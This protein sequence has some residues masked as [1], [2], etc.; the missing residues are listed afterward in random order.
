M[1]DDD[2][3]RLQGCCVFEYAPHGM[4]LT[5]GAD[6]L[7]VEANL[8]FQRAM[9]LPPAALVGRGLLDLVPPAARP[10]LATFLGAPAGTNG[11][12][13][14]EHVDPGGGEARALRWASFPCPRA[15]GRLVECWDVTAEVQ[16]A[17]RLA[18]EVEVLRSE[19]ELLRVVVGREQHLASE[20]ARHAAHLD[21]LLEGMTE[22]VVVAA[23]DGA[24]VLVNR[25][26]R[27]ALAWPHPV[28]S[29]EDL[30]RLEIHRIDGTRVDF[31][32]MPI[33]RA[34]RGERFSEV[35][36]V[37]VRPDGGRR[38]LVFAG[39]AVATPGEREPLFLVVLRDNTE[40]RR[41]EAQRDEALALL[42]HDLRTPIGAIAL[43][44]ELLQRA[45]H[46]RGDEALAATA[47]TLLRGARH[48]AS[49][50]DELALATTSPGEDAGLD[51]AP[52]DLLAVV[53]DALEH[54]VPPEER[55]RVRVEPDAGVPQV[56]ADPERLERAV[57]N[58]ARNAV[59]YSPPGAPVVVRLKRERDEVVLSVEDHGVGISPE[60]VPRLFQK[61]F[62]AGTVGA[63]EG[64][65]LGLY[66][67]RR[68]T[69]AHGGRVWVE[70]EVG[71]GSVFHM[72]LPLSAGGERAPTELSGNGGA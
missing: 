30:R 49:M 18:D 2:V 16:A 25:V 4:A 20:V 45:L 21:A 27:E 63:V 43:R 60:D 32:D 24:I 40:L 11:V 58:L 22:G 5:R 71:R 28:S 65:G 26:A 15:Q 42:S 55:G 37:Y 53:T 13:V 39:C 9:G 51:V 14:T 44:A 61:S 7:V 48:L 72:A 41:A 54:S 17:R 23:A 31:D 56:L 70:S 62:R 8:S 52:V 68:I 59:K 38:W 1:P 33:A 57:A 3:A 66:I 34:M 6:H 29:V 47:A 69:E 64:L 46:E 35:E 36:L 19:H 10:T 12:V 50:L 67:V